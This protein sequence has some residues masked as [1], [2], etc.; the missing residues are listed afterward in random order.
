MS[1]TNV[2]ARRI[3]ETLAPYHDSTDP[4]PVT[5]LSISLPTELV[6]VVRATALETGSTVSATI[7]AALRRTFD[8]VEQ[9]LLDAALEVDQEENLAWADATAPMTATLLAALEW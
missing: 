8:D 9:G 6:E 7:A 1:K 2:S 3:G 5:K 4:A